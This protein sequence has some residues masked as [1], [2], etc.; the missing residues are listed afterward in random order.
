MKIHTFSSIDEANKALEDF[1]KQGL[2][3]INV[4][5][6]PMTDDGGNLRGQLVTIITGWKK[7]DRDTFQKQPYNR[8]RDEY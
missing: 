6:H 7:P 3:V 1:D 8:H 5:V 4:R 2:W